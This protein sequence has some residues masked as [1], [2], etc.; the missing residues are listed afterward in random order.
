MIDV[1]HILAKDLSKLNY[2]SV[3]YYLPEKATFPCISY[4]G[5]HDEQIFSTDNEPGFQRSHVSV[6]VWT[7]TP[8]ESGKIATEVVDVLTKYGWC[9]ESMR[10][11]A[12]DG[13]VYHKVL[14]FVRDIEIN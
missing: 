6:D 12:P 13:G 9:Y 2:T 5:V 11:I 1:N 3:F 7:K 4:Y 14:R 8:A 10:D